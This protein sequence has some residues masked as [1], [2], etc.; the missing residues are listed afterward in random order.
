MIKRIIAN[1][2]ERESEA[3][4]AVLTS[5]VKLKTIK[6]TTAGTPESIRPYFPPKALT[7]LSRSSLCW[8]MISP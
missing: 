3:Q 2:I 7:T 8:L 4:I 6:K 5:W 1:V